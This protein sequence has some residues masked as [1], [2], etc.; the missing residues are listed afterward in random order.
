[1]KG[2][3]SPM[4]PLGS[5]AL[6]RA[7]ASSAMAS[8]R[9]KRGLSLPRELLESTR[10]ESTGPEPDLQG[11]ERKKGTGEQRGGLSAFLGSLRLAW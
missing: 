10:C 9:R 3:V 2:T 11:R 8:M 6:A 7:A 5:L 4:A 1:M